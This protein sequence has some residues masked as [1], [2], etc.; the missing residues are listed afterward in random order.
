MAVMA[1]RLAT[2]VPIL[3]ITHVHFHARLSVFLST[4]GMPRTLDWR[5]THLDNDQP[6]LVRCLD[7]PTL[8]AVS[9]PTALEGTVLAEYNLLYGVRRP[10][11]LS[12]RCLHIHE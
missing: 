8:V 5:A 10:C 3:F 2:K 12:A 9:D 7:L 11:L 4:L 1:N 6:F